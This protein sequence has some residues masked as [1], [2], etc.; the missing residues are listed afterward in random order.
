LHSGFV[1]EPAPRRANVGVRML[2]QQNDVC[3]WPLCLNLNR[4][5]AS[6]RRFREA[7]S[8]NV[9]HPYASSGKL[10]SGDAIRRLCRISAAPL[11]E[12]DAVAGSATAYSDLSGSPFD[13]WPHADTTSEQRRN[14]LHA[15]SVEYRRRGPL[16]QGATL[17]AGISTLMA[18]PVEQKM[19]D[20]LPWLDPTNLDDRL[21][22]SVIEVMR[23]NA[24][25]SVIVVTRDV[26]LQNKLEFARVPF[27]SPEDLGIEEHR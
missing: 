15:K 2:G 6:K 16:L 3:M 20:S 1:N 14:A 22:A 12:I 19:S 18:I 17:A 10:V 24:H 27:V 26:N 7:S 8:P 5:L 25:A 11:D 9:A 23:L 4:S 21:L 13:E